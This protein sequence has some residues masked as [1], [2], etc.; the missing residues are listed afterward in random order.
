MLLEQFFVNRTKVDERILPF[1]RFRFSPFGG[2]TAFFFRKDSG[3]VAQ[4]QKARCFGN[5]RNRH[6]GMLHQHLLGIPDAKPRHPLAEGDTI[7]CLDVGGQVGAVGAKGGG[8]FL[9]GQPRTGITVCIQRSSCRN[10]TGKYRKVW[11]RVST[12]T[13]TGRARTSAARN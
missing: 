4:R 7:S 11:R 10:N 5:G 9:N 13:H 6:F 12:E 1:R 8:Q 3:E 2:R